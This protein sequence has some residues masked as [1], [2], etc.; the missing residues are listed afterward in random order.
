MVPKINQQA[1]Q[2]TYNSVQSIWKKR[3]SLVDSDDF[4]S[5]KAL[6]SRPRKKKKQKKPT[7]FTNFAL[8][9]HDDAIFVLIGLGSRD[10]FLRPIKTVFVA[11]RNTAKAS[12]HT[13]PVEFENAAF[14]LRLGLTSTLIRH[15]NDAFRKRPSNQMNL[16]I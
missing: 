12:S 9:D 11:K 13:A 7:C 3:T 4:T 15:E 1:P 5:W 14:F 10:E 6:N 2:I 16:K 8:T